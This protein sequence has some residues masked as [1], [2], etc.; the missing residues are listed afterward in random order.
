MEA[1]EKVL[2]ALEESEEILKEMKENK[3][4]GYTD[5]KSLF[6]ALNEE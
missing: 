5:T 3:D 1:N 6:E 4:K 2:E